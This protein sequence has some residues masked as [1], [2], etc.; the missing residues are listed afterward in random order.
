MIASACGGKNIRIEDYMPY[1]R[2]D[3]D[4]IIEADPLEVYAKMSKFYAAA[5]KQNQ[6]HK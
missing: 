5:R 2:A 3:D 4:E 1:L 6:Q